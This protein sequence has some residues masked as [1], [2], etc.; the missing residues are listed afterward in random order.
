MP[1]IQLLD[2]I[3]DASRESAGCVVA[4]GSHGGHYPAAICSKFDIRAVVL[5]DAGIGLQQAGV[6]GVLALETVN[7][8]AAAV[9]HDSCYIG[10]A[11]SSQKDGVISV[12]NRVAAKLG[13]YVG[14]HAAEAL[15]L[16]RLAPAPDGR[17][18]PVEE[19]RQELRH[20]QL[21]VL[22]L[23]SA[24]L[25]TQQDSNQI[26]IAGSHGALIGGDPARAL[27]ADASFA[28]F[29]DAGGGLQCIG[30]TRLPALQS[31][32]VAAVTYSHTSARIGDA[33][34]AWETGVISDGNA[35]ASAIGATPGMPLREL[36]FSQLQA[37]R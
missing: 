4:S 13:V 31:R 14:Q 15:E 3:T 24:S 18:P 21:K 23:D 16:L 35:L 1:D 6:A 36:D 25:V 32:G 34:S 11:S 29:N 12:A 37:L 7:C 20:Q 9:S 30:R 26:I 2:S 22:L 17:L 28:A 19:A 5:N 33:A 27:K 10:S 8:A